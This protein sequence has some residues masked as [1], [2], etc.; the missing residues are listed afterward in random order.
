MARKNIFESFEG[1]RQTTPGWIRILLWLIWAAFW[2]GMAVLAVVAL[3]LMLG[4][5]GQHQPV[6]R[7]H[8]IHIPEGCVV[9]DGFGEPCKVDARGGLICNKV[10]LRVS[11]EPRCN[12]VNPGVVEVGR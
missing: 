11:S 1:D 2:V 6:A 9:A 10:H 3:A 7:Y 5:A 4:C 12:G 8:S